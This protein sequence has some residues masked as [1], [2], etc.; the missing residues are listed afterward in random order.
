MDFKILSEYV[1]IAKKFNKPV[2]WNG[3]RH[4]KKAFK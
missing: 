3:L 4:F 1:R 2:T